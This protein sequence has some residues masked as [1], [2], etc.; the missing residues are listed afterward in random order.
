MLVTGNGVTL[1]FVDGDEGDW[2]ADLLKW[3]FAPDTDPV[4][5]NIAEHALDVIC[6][7]QDEDLYTP[8]DERPE[9]PWAI[10][11]TSAE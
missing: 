9:L 1:A 4:Q 6:F 5:D 10:S 8:Q 2:A 7:L 3:L 11:T